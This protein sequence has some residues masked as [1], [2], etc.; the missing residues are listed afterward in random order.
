MTLPS[1]D[2]DDR[3]FEDLTREAIARIPVYLKEWTDHNK[4][5][6]GI[7]FIELFAWL[8]EMQI[9]RLNRIADKSR[10]SFL[11]I[12]GVD[13]EGK[14]LDE[15]EGQARLSLKEITRAVTSEDYEHLAKHCPNLKVAK[16]R[17]LPGYHP[18]QNGEVPGIVTVI[19]VPESTQPRPEPD[20][21]F[22]RDLYKYMDEFR[23][24][25]TELF[26]IG[27]KY[28]EVSITATVIKKPE[29][30]SDTV[31]SAVKNRLEEFLNPL[32]GGDPLQVGEGRGNGWPF[33]RPVFISEIYQTIDN[34]KE[35]D[36][37]KIEK[38]DCMMDDIALI[39]G[40][41]KSLGVLPDV[42]IPKLALVCSG[43][44]NIKVVDS[45]NAE[46][47]PHGQE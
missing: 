5:D 2:L 29:Y 24:L 44:H 27:P 15:A 37:L 31:E 10:E 41:P 34:I 36:Y 16:V 40:Q 28:V 43:V 30:L 39:S 25:T 32:N 14:T 4:S 21:A 45:F 12:A 8:A 20:I 13:P 1:E 19:V 23:L 18:S 22:R 47:N 46:E 33:G 3:S 6:P 7:T 38:V 11:R 9:Y 42:H 26:I 35:V 17:A